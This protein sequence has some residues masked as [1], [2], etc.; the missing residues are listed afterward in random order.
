MWRSNNKIAN[1]FMKIL[2]VAE[3]EGTAIYRLCLYTIKSN[4]QHEFRLVCVHPK[5]PNK[6]QL[7]DFENAYQ[8]CDMVDFR[9][10]KTAELL[11]SMFSIS[12]PAI[13]THYNPYDL[14]KPDLNRYKHHI[15]VNK[16]QAKN[17]K[18][19][20]ILIPLPVDIYFWKYEPMDK[21]TESRANTVIMVANRI[22]GKK[23][24]LEVAQACERLGMKFILVGSPS[25]PA[26]LEQ[27]LSYKCVEFHQAISDEA[28]RELYYK[29]G[30]HVCNSIDKYESGTM[31]ILEAMACGV[32]VLTRRVG[33][34]PEL[35]NGN[36]LAINDSSP[37][38][39][40]ALM[41]HLDDMRGDFEYLKK[42]REE[43]WDTV[44][45]RNIEIYGIH[46]SRLYHQTI[47][48]DDLVSVIIPTYNRAE[49]L[50]KCIAHVV[51]SD[52]GNLEIIIC[53]DGSDDETPQ[54]REALKALEGKPI[55]V[56]YLN[57]GLY[58][59]DGHSFIK[60]YGIGNA[61][62]QG[63]LEAQ[64][65]WILFLDDR[66]AIKPN[67]IREFYHNSEPGK[68]QW[69][70]KD[71]VKKGFVENFSFVDRNTII[72]IGMFSTVIS[73]YGGMTQE[74]RKR[75]EQNGVK[76]E[77]NPKAEASALMKSGA[78]WK[79]LEDI[80]KSKTQCYK[81]GYI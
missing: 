75:A 33:H 44:R 61:R 80:A 69:G 9:Y 28:L 72:K 23:G 1:K 50:L 60:T 79:R 16:E 29:S 48:N 34:V 2:L 70:M 40:E 3:K 53:D 5:R 41:K 73:Q 38:D 42:I 78:K 57:T 30:I 58:R 4:P 62:N 10:W 14:D 68:W 45:N 46:Y 76:L 25:D 21:F 20:P 35:Y 51:A 18:V 37:N 39:V 59:R 19:T 43:A 6:E 65:Q 47:S 22:E 56:K 81:L 12:K 63:I 32:P 17:I 74:C 13:L 66:Q 8:W 55:S 11:H 31:P 71:Q 36:N 15:V 26:Y 7:D 67:A 77:F 64:G 54:V 24:V 52:W 49:T 27:V